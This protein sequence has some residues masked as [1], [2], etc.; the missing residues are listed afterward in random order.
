MH[1][2]EKFITTEP[3]P[4]FYKERDDEEFDKLFAALLEGAEEPLIATPT[5]AIKSPTESAARP[6]VATL[7]KPTVPV[8]TVEAESGSEPATHLTFQDLAGALAEF[9]P[10]SVS[11]ITASLRATSQAIQHTSKTE[12]THP[13]RVQFM[14]ASIELNNRG[15]MPAFR[16]ACRAAP[17]KKGQSYPADDTKLSNDLRIVDLDYLAKHHPHGHGKIFD[18]LLDDDGNLDHGKAWTFVTR[19][20]DATKKAELLALTPN[21][22]AEMFVIRDNKTRQRWKH[23]LENERKHKGM[24]RAA[25]DAGR[26]GGSVGEHWQLYAL[27]V[28]LGWSTKAVIDAV[29]RVPGL[30]MSMITVRRSIPWLTKTAKLPAAGA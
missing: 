20:G 9:Q 2:S 27:C 30:T 21:E 23:L 5:P 12:Y 7:V 10:M 11:E 6:F 18:S 3:H 24:I 17:P 16:P 1:Y 4:G 25:I 13:L 29:A 15:T 19:K 14:A 8:A 22:Q 26:K 28:M